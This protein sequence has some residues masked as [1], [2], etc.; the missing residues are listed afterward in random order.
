MNKAVRPK[1]PADFSYS[2]GWTPVILYHA[3]TQLRDLDV[4]LSLAVA[5]VSFAQDDLIVETGRIHLSNGAVNAEID[6]EDRHPPC[7]HYE[8]EYNRRFNFFP[9]ILYSGVL[10]SAYALFETSLVSLCTSIE[11]DEK[12]QKVYPSQAGRR[13]A[14]ARSAE[15]LLRNFELDITKSQHWSRILDYYKVRNCFVHASGDVLLLKNVHGTSLRAFVVHEAGAG[16]SIDGNDRLKIAPEFVRA[17]ID[18]LK[19]FW[20]ELTQACCANATLGPRFWP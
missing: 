9:S 7:R 19:R 5:S 10:T 14:V 2:I 4:Y 6:E 15:F 8:E 3:E 18:C 12:I 16:I 20:P 17:V 11:K 13:T 1:I